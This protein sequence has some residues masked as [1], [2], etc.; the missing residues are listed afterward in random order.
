[1]I[2]SR[3]S[4]FT[5]VEL[6]VVISIIALL[7]SIL[8]PSLQ[9]ARESARTVACGSNLRQIFQGQTLYAEDHDGL[10]AAGRNNTDIKWR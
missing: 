8:L 6:L 2:V 4:A 10:Y 5:L 1:L 3:R 7:S 9:K